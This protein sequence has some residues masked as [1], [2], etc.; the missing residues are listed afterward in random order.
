MVLAGSFEFWTKFNAEI[1]QRE[2]DDVEVPRV[3]KELRNLGEKK[4]EPPFCHPWSVKARTMI[5]AYLS[6]I[7][8]NS[9]RLDSGKFATLFYSIF[10]FFCSTL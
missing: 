9:P 3:M 5:H 6:R 2:T 1:V 8:L 4:R 7:E 10:D